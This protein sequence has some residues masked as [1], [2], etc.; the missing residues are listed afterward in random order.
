METKNSES[1]Q[2]M[3]ILDIQFPFGRN[4][5]EFRSLPMVDGK[6]SWEKE[7]EAVFQNIPIR[8]RIHSG[9]G[10]PLAD[11]MKIEG[12]I[13]DHTYIF[14]GMSGYMG[15]GFNGKFREEFV[16]GDVKIICHNFFSRC[17]I[18]G[19][20]LPVPPV[21][22]NPRWKKQKRKRRK[23]RLPERWRQAHLSSIN[24]ERQS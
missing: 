10:G 13:G 11:Y 7:F 20:G 18:E 24:K 12:T 23:N 22:P 9:T 19:Y 16:F 2:L 21:L 4:K 15:G 1:Y 8:I 14:K 5:S 3:T 17:R 6:F